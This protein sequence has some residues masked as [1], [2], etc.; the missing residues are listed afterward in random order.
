[1]CELSSYPTN[2]HIGVP[3]LGQMDFTEDAVH[4]SYIQGGPKNRAALIFLK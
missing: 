1:M 2:Y 4:S 3:I